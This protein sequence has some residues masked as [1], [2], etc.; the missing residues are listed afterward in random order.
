MGKL[1]MSKDGQTIL[2]CDAHCVRARAYYQRYKLPIKSGG[3]NASGIVGVRKVL[4]ILAS[5]V[6]GAKSS[7]NKKKLYRN[8][9]HVTIDNYFSGDKI[10]DWVSQNR[11]AA[12][13]TCRRDR[14]P[15][16]VPAKYWNKQKI[17]TSK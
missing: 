4:E 9:P 13:M 6:D 11:F 7:D 3:Q 1:N 15:S 10:S 5:M 14:L 2:I 12:T 8:K 16:G 17:D